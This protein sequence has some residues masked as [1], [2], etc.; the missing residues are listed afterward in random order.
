MSYLELTKMNRFRVVERFTPFVELNGYDQKC[1]FYTGKN[2][3]LVVELCYAPPFN[4]DQ[5]LV[6]CSSCFEINV[7]NFFAREHSKNTTLLVIRSLL[8]RN[9][10]ADLEKQLH[11]PDKASTIAHCRV[12]W[13]RVGPQREKNASCM[14]A[15]N[16]DH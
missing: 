3:Y 8:L 1:T 13:L 11:L 15:M 4:L 6:H 12:G 2:I 7:F 5:Y 9:L 14:R 10:E 16:M